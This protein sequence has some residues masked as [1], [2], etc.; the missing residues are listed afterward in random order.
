[1]PLN[2]SVNRKYFPALSRAPSAPGSSHLAG[3]GILKPAGGGP[4][5]SAERREEELK[6]AARIGDVRATLDGMRGR[7]RASIVSER[8]LAMAIE[9]DRP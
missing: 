7:E 3:F 2:I 9:A 1:M 4:E 6:V 5:G 8:A